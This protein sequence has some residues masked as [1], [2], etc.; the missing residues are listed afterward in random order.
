MAEDIAIGTVYKNSKHG[1]CEFQLVENDFI[2]PA[3][4]YESERLPWSSSKVAC[5][6]CGQ[7]NGHKHF[8]TGT[9]CQPERRKDGKDVYWKLISV[10]RKV[11]KDIT[12]ENIGQ[13]IPSW[14]NMQFY[15]KGIHDEH[16]CKNCEKFLTRNEYG[17]PICTE[18]CEVKIAYDKKYAEDIWH[19]RNCTNPCYYEAHKHEHDR[20]R[21]NE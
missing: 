2:N 1:Y 5:A 10:G 21:I 19:Q 7:Y 13:Y 4:Y 14:K 17:T 9:C 6:V 3:V 16:P 12:E 18:D 20:Y 8:C 15:K 11:K